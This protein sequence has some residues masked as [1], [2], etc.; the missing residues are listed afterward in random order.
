MHALGEHHEFLICRVLAF[1]EGVGGGYE[2]IVLLEHTAHNKP[3][4]DMAKEW[5]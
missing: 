3:Q 4:R 2:C 5:P 1:A